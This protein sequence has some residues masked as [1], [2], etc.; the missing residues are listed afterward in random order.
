MR[1]LPDPGNNRGFAPDV[2]VESLLSLSKSEFWGVPYRSGS[3]PSFFLF[4]E[5]IGIENS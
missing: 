2:F 1:L 5:K 4:Q 3:S